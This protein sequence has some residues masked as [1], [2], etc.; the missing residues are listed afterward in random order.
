[1]ATQQVKHENGDLPRGL[2]PDNSGLERRII[3]AKGVESYFGCLR[4]TMGH[5]RTLEQI[6]VLNG[7]DVD[8]VADVVRNTIRQDHPN[9][10]LQNSDA[11]TMEDLADNINTT[12][13]RERA[14]FVEGGTEARQNAGTGSQAGR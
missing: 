13:L 1:M 4:D 9:L 7:A 10:S 3:S 6:G 12:A 14:A 5:V 2:G 8:A 11:K